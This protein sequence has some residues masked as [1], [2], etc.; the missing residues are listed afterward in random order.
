M[1]KNTEKRGAV[2]CAA[3][4]ILLVA[5]Y[6]IALAAI[7]LTSGD[8]GLGVLS[9]VALYG[10]ILVAIAVGILL[11]LRQRLKE[12]DGGEEDAAKQY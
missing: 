12:I 7:L 4:I 3:V 11:A 5:A 2:L 8:R 1:R 9:F 10:G 6:I